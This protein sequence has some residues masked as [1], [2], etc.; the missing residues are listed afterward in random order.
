MVGV[1]CGRPLFWQGGHVVRIAQISQTLV[2][3]GYRFHCCLPSVTDAL[4][5]LVAKDFPMVSV[6][7]SPEAEAFGGADF[8]ELQVFD[9]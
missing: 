3:G 7:L 6:L 5:A 8:P 9:G 4:E 2:G 1:G